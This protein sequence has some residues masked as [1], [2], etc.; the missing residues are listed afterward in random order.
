MIL[1]VVIALTSPGIADIQYWEDFESYEEGHDIRSEVGW[2][3]PYRG[4]PFVDSGVS[5]PTLSNGIVVPGNNSLTTE[6][7]GD[8]DYGMFFY[9]QELGRPLG[10]TSVLGLWVMRG[11][12]GHE[13]ESSNVIYIRYQ[14]TGETGIEY[15]LMSEGNFFHYRCRD[16]WA[17]TDIPCEL[18]TWYRVMWVATG[19]SVDLHLADA[20]GDNDT[21]LHS[22]TS[23]TNLST[24]YL[25]FIRKDTRIDNVFIADSIGDVPP[26][27]VTVTAIK[28]AGKLTTTWGRIK[29]E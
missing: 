2:D 20:N 23:I 25:V 17:N 12:G 13:H 7:S 21:L 3:T 27:P 9:F 29:A 1:V 11:P 8:G 28:S 15:G 19:T 4:T 18:D 10:D 14:D 16:P 6:P 5:M 24:L 22:C 26:L